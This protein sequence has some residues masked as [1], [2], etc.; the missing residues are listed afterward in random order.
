MK[1]FILMALCLSYSFLLSGCGQPS[2]VE[3]IDCDSP[4]LTTAEKE[5]ANC[6]WDLGDPTERSQNKGF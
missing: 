4:S 6:L 1:V 3:Q 5:Q 2:N